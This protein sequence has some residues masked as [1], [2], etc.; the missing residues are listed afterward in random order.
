MIIPPQVVSVLVARK[1]ALENTLTAIGSHSGQLAEFI[2]MQGELRWANRERESYTGTL[3]DTS[4]RL[5][6]DRS[7]QPAITAL[8]DGAMRGTSSEETVSVKYPRLGQR[9]MAVRAQPAF[10]NQQQ[11]GVL[12]TCTD[13]TQLESSRQKLQSLAKSLELANND[14]KHF[15]RVSSHDLVEPLNTIA[16]FSSLIEQ[17]DPLA[18]WETTCE[19]LLLIQQASARMSATLN[20]IRTYIQI[21]EAVNESRFCNIDIR[22]L[23]EEVL[24]RL[25]R[26]IKK[27]QAEVSLQL[28]GSVF[29]DKHHVSLAI[30]NLLSNALKFVTPGEKPLVYVTSYRKGH[31]SV[32][33][34]C[35]KGIGIPQDKLILLAWPFK[36]L[37]SRNQ[38]DGTGLG[39]AICQRIANRHGGHLEI[40]SQPG[41]GS[42]F[43]IVLPEKT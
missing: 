6:W 14:L 8:V 12:L 28:S 19:Y 1:H 36:R 37:H 15:L 9:T 30:E 13:I 11:I 29:G 17:L 35:D 5:K 31:S 27:S 2:D 16:Q 39:L 20:D 18:D 21:D 26:D 41:V 25:R 10:D 4:A 23:I 3:H 24:D 7:S 43:A 32:I 33:E 34:V 42:R 40:S 38:Y 22:A